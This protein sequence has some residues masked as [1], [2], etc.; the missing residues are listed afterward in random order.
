VVVGMGSSVE[1]ARKAVAPH[2][3]WHAR[4]EREVE[5][6]P[7][8]RGV[9]QPCRTAAVGGRPSEPDD[10]LVLL[11]SVTRD[12]H[13]VVARWRVLVCRSPVVDGRPPH[14]DSTDR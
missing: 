1:P 12:V 9:G 10:R 11:G 5:R 6:V 14:Q 13:D 7:W 3:P 8:T 2:S 4:V